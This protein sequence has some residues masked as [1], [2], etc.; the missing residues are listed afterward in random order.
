MTKPIRARSRLLLGTVLLTM[1]VFL[2]T[3]FKALPHTRTCDCINVIRRGDDYGGWTMCTPRYSL[4]NTIIYTI[5]IGRNIKW[6]EAMMNQFG[7][8]HHGWD[9]TPTAHDFFSKRPIPDRFVFHR[10][11]LASYDGDL[12]LKLPEGNG[13]S[14]TVMEQKG[15]AQE[16]K[17]GVYPVL[18]LET[19]MRQ[20]GHRHLAVLKIDVE[21][22]EFDV[23]RDWHERSVDLSTDQMLIEFHARYFEKG[24]EMVCRA[25]RDMD[26]L[27][28]MLVHKTKLEYTFAKKRLIGKHGNSLAVNPVIMNCNEAKQD[29]A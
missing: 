6:D 4:K 27:G 2:I 21:G 3:V 29:P 9:P 18:K 8:I 23:I 7:T 28:F 1:V 20:N 15:T 25:V 14:Y 17:V 16:G 12:K 26:D 11:G 19:M 13:D 22:A 10:V 24:D 5:G